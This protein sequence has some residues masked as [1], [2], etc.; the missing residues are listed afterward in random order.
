M[1]LEVYAVL[2]C[3]KEFYC[4]DCNISLRVAL[5]CSDYIISLCEKT[6]V[7]K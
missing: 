7:L 3:S 4:S 1:P 5:Y 2:Y 6:A